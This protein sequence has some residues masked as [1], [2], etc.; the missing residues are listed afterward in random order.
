MHL[1][2]YE[3]NRNRNALLINMPQLHKPKEIIVCLLPTV[4]HIETLM[5]TTSPT[6][7]SNLAK[8]LCYAFGTRDPT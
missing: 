5:T 7:L 8:Y 2:Q 6:T 4:Q 1:M 3:R